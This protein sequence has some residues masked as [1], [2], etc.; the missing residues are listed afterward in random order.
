MALSNMLN[1]KVASA[2]TAT[3]GSQDY[4]C[5]KQNCVFTPMFFDPAKTTII[6]LWTN[7]NTTKTTA[8]SRKEKHRG[9][10]TT[11][12]HGIIDSN[13]QIISS[14]KSA[15]SAVGTH[16][17]S[18]REIMLGF[19]TWMEETVFEDVQIPPS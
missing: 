12:Y 7:T 9:F 16:A 3:N 4:I 17:E 18:I 6:I 5:V 11:L 10:P 13:I 14:P 1:L 15:K 8:S 2:Y 19:T